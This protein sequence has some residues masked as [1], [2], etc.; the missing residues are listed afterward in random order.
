MFLFP[1]KKSKVKLLGVGEICVESE[2]M[3]LSGYLWKIQGEKGNLSSYKEDPGF[4]TI[5]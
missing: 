2:G 1:N 3:Y 5:L 4:Q